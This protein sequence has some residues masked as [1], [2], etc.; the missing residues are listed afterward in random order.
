MQPRMRQAFDLVHI[1]RSDQFAGA[2]M[3]KIAQ[4]VDAA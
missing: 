1:V 4:R 2:G 3:L